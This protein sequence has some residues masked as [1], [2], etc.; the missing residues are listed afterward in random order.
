[1]KVKD[2]INGLIKNEELTHIGSFGVDSGMT[3]IGDP[4]YIIHSDEKNN[5]LGEDWGDLC[6][7]IHDEKL[8]KSFNYNLGHEGLGVMTSTHNG[9]GKYKVF[10]IGDKERPQGIIIDFCLGDE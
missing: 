6:S 9:D 10:S 5:E 3:W 2:K 4:C 7:I 8:P 1:M